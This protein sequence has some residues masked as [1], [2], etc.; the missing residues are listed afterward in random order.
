MQGS[1]EIP[2]FRT[3]Y[4]I[5]LYSMHVTRP[6]HRPTFA[7]I[8]ERLHVGLQCWPDGCPVLWPRL[9]QGG[10]PTSSI[11]S[12]PPVKS[13]SESENLALECRQMTAGQGLCVCVCVCVC[14][15]EREKEQEARLGINARSGKLSPPPP[16][17]TLYFLVNC[18]PH[19][20]LPSK[21]SPAHFTS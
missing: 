20:L 9:A 5:V 6:D 11:P 2:T 10:G 1:K 15:R 7:R 8:V 3:A 17:R 18:P 21:L 4:S 16:P 12:L 13:T 14:V 19:T